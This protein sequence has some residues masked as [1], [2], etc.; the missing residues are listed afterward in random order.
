MKVAFKSPLEDNEP[1]E[2]DT[3]K[4]NCHWGITAHIRHS[5]IEH[6]MLQ[7]GYSLDDV[8]VVGSEVPDKS[9]KA[10]Y[11]VKGPLQEEIRC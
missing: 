7:A 4:V 11:K 1:P 2:E 9:G 8:I 10:G 6:D 3:V 5:Q